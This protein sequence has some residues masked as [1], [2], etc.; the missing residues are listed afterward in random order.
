MFV[1][2]GEKNIMFGRDMFYRSATLPAKFYQKYL[3]KD[4][5]V[6]LLSSTANVSWSEYRLCCVRKL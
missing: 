6:M 3:N 2:E 4:P 1:R 5:A